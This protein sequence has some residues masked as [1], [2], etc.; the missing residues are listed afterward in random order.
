MSKKEQPYL[1]FEQGPIRPPSEAH[2]LLLRVTRNCPW[3][4]CEFCTVY[5]DSKFTIRSVDHVIEDIE[6]IHKYVE[7]IRG[8]ADE[9]GNIF[10]EDL[11][12]LSKQAEPDDVNIFAAALNWLSKGME[13]VFLQDANSLV[14]KPAYLIQILTHIRRRFPWVQRITSYAR[15]HSLARIKDDDFKQIKE[16]GLNR[17]HVG[18]ETGSDKILKLVNK[19]AT[20]EIHIK[21]GHNVKKA[22]IELSEYIMPGLGGKQLSEL[23][24]IE[25]ADALNQIDADFIRLRTLTIADNFPMFGENPDVPFEKPTDMEMVREIRKTIENIEGITSTLKSD[26]MNNL[27]QTVEGK[28][29]D[30]KQQ[31]L[32]TIDELLSQDPLHQTYF[33]VG[34][35]FGFMYQTSD[36]SKTHLLDKSKEICQQLNITPEN[37]D[38]VIDSHIRRSL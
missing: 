10:R 1:G 14:I 11:L 3:N 38:Q 7:L 12:A 35:R 15:S 23:H 13:S 18:L 9:N 33:Q 19:G 24:A 25:T 29:P 20:K 32:D 34:R 21:G 30:D 8:L 16:A 2:S 5:K 17:I 26:H 22:G 6:L 4:K 37:A 36:L 28:F 31:M 27:L